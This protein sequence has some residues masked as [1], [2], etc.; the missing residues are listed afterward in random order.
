M[1]TETNRPDDGKSVEHSDNEKS[2]L[3]ER[4][5][6]NRKQGPNDRPGKQTGE[7]EAPVG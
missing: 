5:D 2:K 7:G 4:D 3:P 6:E 1:S